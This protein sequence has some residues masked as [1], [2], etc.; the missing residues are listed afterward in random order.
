ML[1]HVAELKPSILISPSCGFYVVLGATCLW[2]ALALA[3]SS[4]PSAKRSWTSVQ[5]LWKEGAE[6]RGYEL[7]LP[8]GISVVGL[9]LNEPH[10]VSDL[11]LGQGMAA[12]QS[13]PD[14]L[15]QVSPV[16]VNTWSASTRVDAWVLPFLNL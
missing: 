16:E 10:E 14:S 3:Q 15:L 11:R 9:G 12:P 7:P 2:P 13:V 6:K 8:F 1:R 5:P 4:P